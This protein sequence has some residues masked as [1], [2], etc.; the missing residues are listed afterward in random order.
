MSL[1]NADRRNPWHREAGDLAVGWS[2]HWPQWLFYS[3]CHPGRRRQKHVLIWFNFQMS[4]FSWEIVLDFCPFFGEGG[5]KTDNLRKTNECHLE[6]WRLPSSRHPFVAGWYIAR[7]KWKRIA[8]LCRVY[9]IRQAQWNASLQKIKW[10]CRA[11]AYSSEA[12]SE[13]H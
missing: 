1:W 4:Y 10:S 11:I 6:P 13:L 8:R 9:R 2:W 7:T 3:V 12:P 5:C